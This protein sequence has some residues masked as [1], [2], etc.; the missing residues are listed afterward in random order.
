MLTQHFNNLAQRLSS[1]TGLTNDIHNHILAVTSLTGMFLRYQHFVIDTGIFR[2]HETDTAFLEK[3]AHGL[4]GT[5]LEHLDNDAF[6]AP[7]VVNPIH[8][9]SHPVAVKDLAHLACG[10]E[11]V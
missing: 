1:H 7:P 5:V 8:P 11:Q 6:A 10:Q 9:G 2:H 4:I 3:P